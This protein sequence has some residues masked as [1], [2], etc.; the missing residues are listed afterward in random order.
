MTRCAETN[1]EIKHL[2]EIKEQI[3]SS[4]M[5]IRITLND[6]RKIDGVV[7]SGRNGN[8]NGEGNYYGE[9][10]I[11]TEDR[12]MWSIDYLDIKSV[13]NIWKLKAA[14]YER[15]GLITIVDYPSS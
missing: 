13:A 8:L 9:I 3:N 1:R 2:I 6:G 14:E 7:R 5:I 15:L 10:T 11:E 12:Q 4:G